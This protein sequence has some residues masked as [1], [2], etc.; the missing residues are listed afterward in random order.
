MKHDYGE[1]L[2]DS[3]YGVLFM[4]IVYIVILFNNPWPLC[5]INVM[6]KINYIIVITEG[7][8]H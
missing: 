2:R 4:F 3:D 6:V 1:A 5:I 7:R 8:P